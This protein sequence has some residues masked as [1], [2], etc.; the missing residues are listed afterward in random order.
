[1]HSIGDKKTFHEMKNKTQISKCMP[2]FA[3][4]H[5]GIL[6]LRIKFLVSK[7]SD[8][9]SNKKR[10]MYITYYSQGWQTAV[11]GSTETC[12]SFPNPS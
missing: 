4:F 11:I 8:F 7:K 9:N 1:M 6:S 12:S 3:A 5:W 2:N 10:T